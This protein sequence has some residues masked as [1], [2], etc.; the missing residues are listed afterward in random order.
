[1]HEM[2]YTQAIL[3]L[4]LEQAAGRKIRGIR[5]RVGWMS[6]IVPDSVAA[7]FDHLSQGT[8]AQGAELVFDMTSIRLICEDCA[9]IIELPYDPQRNPRHAL[10]EIFGKGCPCGG[11][12]LKI[13]DG[14]GFDLAGI[15]VGPA[16]H[17]INQ[18]HPWK[19]EKDGDQGPHRV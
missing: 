5:M 14:L 10:A 7:F 16:E 3:E 6:A 13:L 15:E 8:G 11:G 19:E 18:A 1:M 9:R 2:P 12:A 4:A 17:S